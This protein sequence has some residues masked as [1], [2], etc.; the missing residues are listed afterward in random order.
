MRKIIFPLLFVLLLASYSVHVEGQ[1]TY[2]FIQAD[3]FTI[4]TTHDRAVGENLSDT[5]TRTT[6]ASRYRASQ[7]SCT[8]LRKS[9]GYFHGIVSFDSVGSAT[10]TLM[11]L[12]D[13]TV[14]T[15]LLYR[16]LRSYVNGSSRIAMGEWLEAEFYD[17]TNSTWTTSVAYLVSGTT[18]N[19][20][21]YRVRFR[22]LMWSEFVEFT[23]DIN[24]SNQYT[25]RT[26]LIFFY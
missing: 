6:T 20:T 15:K 10:D 9:S 8:A 1:A 14:L 5:I 22:N 7:D 23:I 3:S 25:F 2:S 4:T 19:T 16:H 24:D 12:A 18:A 26:D 21:S 13:T 11:A 17:S